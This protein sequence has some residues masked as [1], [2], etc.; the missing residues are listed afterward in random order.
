MTWLKNLKRQ[1]KFRNLVVT[2]GKFGATLFNS[3]NKIFNVP[4]FENNPIDT[5][6]SGDTFFAIISLC[7]GSGLNEE[8]SLFFASLAASYSV[9]KVGSKK[10]FNKENLFQDIKY[11]F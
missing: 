7:L 1:I 4:A 10:Y 9:N 11:L 8:V 3:K 6:G 2:Q 5:I